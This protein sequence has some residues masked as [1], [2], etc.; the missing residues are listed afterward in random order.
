MAPV[1]EP[2]VGGMP[3]PVLPVVD[4]PSVDGAV[5]VVDVPAPPIDVLLCELAPPDGVP[6]SVPGMPPVTEPPVLYRVPPSVPGMPPVVDPP[7]P[8]LGVEGVDWFVDLGT[9]GSAGR[10]TLPE[11]PAVPPRPGVPPG[12]AVGGVVVVPMLCASAGPAIS[13]AATANVV[14]RTR[15]C[16]AHLPIEAASTDRTRR[17]SEDAR[18]RDARS[19]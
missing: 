6:P 19:T 3:V 8:V 15:N 12:S 18:R 1:V 13:A 17:A 10:R 5:S 11:V 7:I 4:P 14:H 2:P 16:M 9:L